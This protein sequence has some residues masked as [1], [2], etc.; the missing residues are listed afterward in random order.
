[1]NLIEDEGKVGLYQDGNWVY[2][3]YQD[4][5]IKLTLPW[6]FNSNGIDRGWKAVSADFL[7]NPSHIARDYPYEDILLL[8]ENGGDD[9]QALTFS[10]STGYITGLVATDQD[11]YTNQE[12]ND[13]HTSTSAA[14]YIRHIFQQQD[15]ILMTLYL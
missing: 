13:L 9:W 15:F 11:Y 1:M 10:T 8:W 5:K 3:E 7:P 6:N 12:L 4:K 14:W 2:A